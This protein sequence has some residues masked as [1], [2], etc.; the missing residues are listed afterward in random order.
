MS[1]KRVRRELVVTTLT[2]IV[3]SDD[4]H[5]HNDCPQMSG[6]AAPLCARFGR[7]EW[8]KRCQRH[9]Y[10]R[11]PECVRKAQYRSEVEL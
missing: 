11:H 8:D 4:K 9:G 7:L 2:D 6:D 10:K 5:C 3:V 1:V